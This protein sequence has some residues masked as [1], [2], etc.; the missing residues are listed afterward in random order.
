VVT[1]SVFEMNDTRKPN[2]S[3][4]VQSNMGRRRGLP[5]LALLALLVAR[6]GQAQN[7]NTGTSTGNDVAKAEVSK[8]DAATSPEPAPAKVDAATRVTTPDTKSDTNWKDKQIPDWSEA[9]AKQLLADSPWVKKSTAVVDKTAEKKSPLRLGRHGGFGLSGLGIGR[10]SSSNGS[11]STDNGNG[12]S[13]SSSGAAGVP[14]APLVVTLRWAS[15]LPIREAELKARDTRAP[16][17]DEDHYAIEVYGIPSKQVKDDSQKL[18]D[19]LKAKASIK[20]LAKDELKP[21]SVEIVM[22][23]DGPVLVYLFPR[24]AEIIWRDHEINFEAEVGNVKIKQAFQTDEMKF[25]G[26]LEL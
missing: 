15:A 20:R 16:M 1:T 5:L 19:Q 17:V 11:N 14:D 24:R 4:C 26:V 2:A 3:R 7:A 18:A 22:R 21:S 23:D 6:S 25:H 13:S 10:R 9:D 12:S 8:V